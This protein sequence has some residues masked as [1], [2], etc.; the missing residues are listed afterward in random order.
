MKKTHASNQLLWGG[1]ILP[2]EINNPTLANFF[3][4]HFKM[5]VIPVKTEEIFQN[6]ENFNFKGT[7]ALIAFAKK[8]NLITRGH[9]L[10]W[11]HK[12][13]I[14]K[15]IISMPLNDLKSFLNFSIPL[16]ISRLKKNINVWD[17]FNEPSANDANGLNLSV[18]SI[19]ELVKM[20]FKIARS[21]Q[22][23]A[24]LILNFSDIFNANSFIDPLEFIKL[25]IKESVDLDSLGLQ[26]HFGPHRELRLHDWKTIKK[27][28]KQFSVFKK[29]VHITELS[30]PSSSFIDPHCCF[31]KNNPINFGFPP[32]WSEQNQFF[33][34]RELIQFLKTLKIVKSITWWDLTDAIKTNS[35]ISTFV[36]FGGL[37]NRQKQTKLIADQL[38]SLTQL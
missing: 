23:K 24:E 38:K 20:S 1:R 15:W 6:K 10:V 18:K 17:V 11:L 33:F 19:L 5:I 34:T 22:P 4:E 8:N 9:T 31:P 14:P 36:N 7:E 16:T 26:L 30:V 32:K 35:G 37:F 28:L 12:R 2:E 3:L 21:C 13:L 25:A 29:P 27:R